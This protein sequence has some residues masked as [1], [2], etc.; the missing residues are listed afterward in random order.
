M[1]LFE[2]QLAEY[3]LYDAQRLRFV[4]IA[5]AR[6]T[7]EELQAANDRFR[8]AMCG[9]LQWKSEAE[10]KPRSYTIKK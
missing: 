7:N 9:H 3:R 5:P 1:D 2:D 6:L 8:K 4:P 10:L